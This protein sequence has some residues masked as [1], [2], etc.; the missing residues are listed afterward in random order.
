MNFDILSEGDQHWLMVDPHP[1]LFNDGMKVYQIVDELFT[2][3]NLTDLEWKSTVAGCSLA[4]LQ[5]RQT[6]FLRN[7]SDRYELNM[8]SETTSS[9]TFFKKGARLGT[10]M[11]VGNPVLMLMQYGISVKLDQLSGF[12]YGNDQFIVNGDAV[13]NDFSEA[14]EFY[15]SHVFSDGREKALEGTL[16]VV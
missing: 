1:S 9:L 15:C 4:D 6:S 11:D 10:G 2:M 13:F 7:M 14:L 3:H 16:D 5:A 12:E 8:K